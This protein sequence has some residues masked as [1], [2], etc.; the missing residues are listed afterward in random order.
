MGLLAYKLQAYF[1]SCYQ[2]TYLLTFFFFFG[3]GGVGMEYMY[4]NTHYKINNKTEQKRPAVYSFL[5]KLSS[6]W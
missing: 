6:H 2:Q 3:G 1:S 4:V 5:I